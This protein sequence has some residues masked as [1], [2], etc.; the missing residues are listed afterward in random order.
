MSP[1]EHDLYALQRTLQALA[2]RMDT[3]DATV[4]EL[5]RIV[6]LSL[7]VAQDQEVPLASEPRTNR[8]KATAAGYSPET[9]SYLLRAPNLTTETERAIAAGYDAGEAAGRAQ[10]RR[11]DDQLR[12]ALDASQAEVLVLKDRVDRA[13]FDLLDD[14]T[15]HSKRA[16][17]DEE[18]AH[19][20]EAAANVG[21]A[22]NRILKGEP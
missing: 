10:G 20:T 16:T 14:L 5:Q 2:K 13:M 17:S 21:K 4:A 7:P 1:G 6:A 19:W 11:R 8:E 22:L 12:K 9:I 15:R 3:N 18:R